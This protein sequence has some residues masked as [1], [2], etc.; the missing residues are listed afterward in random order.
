MGNFIQ[1]GFNENKKAPTH[2]MEIIEAGRY[3]ISSNKRSGRLFQIWVLRGELNRGRALIRGGRLIKKILG[4]L[5]NTT[6][7]LRKN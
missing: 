4:L 3:R 7:N 5:I 6:F 1:L 2:W